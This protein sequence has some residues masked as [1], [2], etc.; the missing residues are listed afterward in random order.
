MARV[1]TLESAKADT[2]GLYLL[3]RDCRYSTRK[4]ISLPTT[5]ATVSRTSA[6]NSSTFVHGPS[7]CLRLLKDSWVGRVS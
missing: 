7:A 3:A 2:G 6:G 1:V 4:L 5:V